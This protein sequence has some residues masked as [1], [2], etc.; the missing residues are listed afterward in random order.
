MVG[1]LSW[2]ANQRKV[3][4]LGSVGIFQSH[5]HEGVARVTVEFRE[6]VYVELELNMPFAEKFHARRL[7]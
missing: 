5:F 2:Q 6:M 4:I 1:S 3:M 7:S